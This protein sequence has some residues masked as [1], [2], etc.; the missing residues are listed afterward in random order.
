MKLYVTTLRALLALALL[1]AQTICVWAADAPETA[2]GQSNLFDMSM[3]ELMQ[4]EVVSASRRPQ[5]IGH[6]SAPVTVITAEDIHYSGLT[7]IYEVLQFA[8]GIDALQLDRN[9]YAL[10]IHG[11]HEA[12]SD[13]TLTLID[14]RP[15]DNPMFGGSQ[16]LRL[17]VL[18]QD[19]ERIEVVRGPAGAAWGANAL[20]GVINIITKKPGDCTGVQAST[21]WNEFGD[22]YHHVR[23]ADRKGPSTWRL[24]LGYEAQDTSS[25]ALHD[26]NFFSTHPFGGGSFDSRDFRRSTIV[27]TQF[28]HRLSEDTEL[29]FGAGHNHQEM[30]DFGFIGYV[31][32]RNGF[33]ENTRTHLKID[34]KIDETTSGFIQWAG[35][36]SNIFDPALC[37]YRTVENDLQVQLNF[38]PLEGHDMSVGGHT[39]LTRISQDVVTAED[40]IL[41]GEPLDEQSVG[42]FVID[43]WAL[44]DRWTLEAQARADWYSETQTDWAGRFTAFRRLD[45]E[46]KHVLRFSTAKAFRAPRASLRRAQTSRLFHT[47]LGVYLAELAPGGDLDNEETWTLE[48]GYTGIIDNHLT[49]TANAYFQQY[50]DLIGYSKISSGPGG[51]V[52]TNIP[53]NI[54]DAETIGAEFELSHKTERSRLSAWYVYQDFDVEGVLTNENDFQDTRAFAPAEHKIGL[55]GRFFF[56]DDWVLNLNYKHSAETDATY[57][58]GR[59][60]TNNPFPPAYDRVDITLTKPF[61]YDDVQ[62]E[63]MIGVTDVFNE[64]EFISKSQGHF[65]YN[66]EVPGRTLFMRCLFRF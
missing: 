15:A 59:E 47:G 42:G 1:Q 49:F 30:G 4:V 36:F 20:N 58:S 21:Q 6:L 64:T 32:N 2:A 11:L 19:I 62:G 55:T 44:T 25:D 12:F 46:D 28:T 9:N 61:E 29:S 17:P 5:T 34:R 22:N 60:S 16:F 50:D 65:Y 8:L 24:S 23:Y 63:F 7:N 40:I 66:H 13:R 35:N 38:Q 31:P 10:G 14:G 48:A 18:L 27:D 53:S 52:E 41:N 45:E 3:E 54:G 26:E 56:D 33:S 37:K 43:R 51:A 39:T 57:I